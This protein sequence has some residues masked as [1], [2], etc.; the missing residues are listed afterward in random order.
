[1]FKY[2]KQA[3]IKMKQTRTLN[4]NWNQWNQA[5]GDIKDIPEED[6]QRKDFI[7]QFDLG[8]GA[9]FEYYTGEHDDRVLEVFRTKQK[10]RAQKMNLEE[11]LLTMSRMEHAGYNTEILDYA[12]KYKKIETNISLRCG[13]YTNSG[14]L[15]CEI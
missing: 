10:S 11:V 4:I 3:H 5:V 14:K 7:L 12:K 1:M 6:K 9:K 13:V 15:A 8:G 2:R